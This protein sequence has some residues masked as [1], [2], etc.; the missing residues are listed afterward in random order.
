MREVRISDIPATFYVGPVGVLV[1]AEHPRLAELEARRVREDSGGAIAALPVVLAPGLQEPQG[2]IDGVLALRDDGAIR[3]YLRGRRALDNDEVDQVAGWLRNR[4][5]PVP[6][7]RPKE[8]RHRLKGKEVIEG[9]GRLPP[10]GP[11]A[12][13]VTGLRVELIPPGPPPRPGLARLAWRAVGWVGWR[14]AFLP[15]LA[16]LV[17]GATSEPRSVWAWVLLAVLG[18]RFFAL[19][20]PPQGWK[21]RVLVGVG[22]LEVLFGIA[23]IATNAFLSTRPTLK[24]DEVLWMVVIFLLVPGIISLL[25]AQGFSPKWQGIPWRPLRSRVR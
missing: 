17:T 7:I 20:G 11:S 15:E 5:A 6:A 4:R 12:S 9:S 22:A 10:F 16:L 24:F 25:R 19:Y 2:R 8:G 3:E 13:P 1:V 21:R 18:L 14:V 23:V